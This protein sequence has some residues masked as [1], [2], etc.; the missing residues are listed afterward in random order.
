M[1]GAGPFSTTGDIIPPCKIQHRVKL[2]VDP[3]QTVVEMW[4]TKSADGN[5]KGAKNQTRVFEWYPKGAN[6]HESQENT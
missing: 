6:T 2:S 3:K 5:R 1:Y 4:L